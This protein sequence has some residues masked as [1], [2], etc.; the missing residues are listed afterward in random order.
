[1]RVQT[2]TLV[3]GAR[4]RHPRLGYRPASITTGGFLVFR[5]HSNSP[6]YIAARGGGTIDSYL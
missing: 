5:L 3:D 6:M 1:M 2:R 4:V